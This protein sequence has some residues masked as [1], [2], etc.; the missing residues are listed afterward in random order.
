MGVLRP[1]ALGISSY[2]VVRQSVDSQVALTAFPESTYLAAADLGHWDRMALDC[3]TDVP[4]R[5][6]PLS[7]VA[8]RRADEVLEQMGR[9]VVAP[10]R[11]VPARLVEVC[12]RGYSGLDL[13]AS[14]S[15][16]FDPKRSFKG[17][18]NPTKKSARVF[19]NR[20]VLAGGDI[21]DGGTSSGLLECHP[22]CR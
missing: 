17:P 10:Q 16:H 18:H 12:L 3:P 4:R 15:S 21:C 5:P 1:E 14:S 19:F 6:R 8:Q 22:L 7:Q 13:L 2:D 9:H 11:Q 20:R